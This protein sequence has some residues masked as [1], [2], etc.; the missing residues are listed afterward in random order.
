MY[1]KVLADTHHGVPP[2]ASRVFGCQVQ[3]NIRSPG[4]TDSDIVALVLLLG[5]R[6]SNTA[7]IDVVLGALSRK[8]RLTDS[9]IAISRDIVGL[10]LGQRTSN[11]ARINV[12]F[13]KWI[14]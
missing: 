1:N 9:D 5:Q 13:L 11:T 2:W 7:R 8:R 4:P 6:P 3:V 12:H 14:I 10:S